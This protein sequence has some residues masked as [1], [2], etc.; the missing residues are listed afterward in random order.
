LLPQWPPFL[1]LQIVTFICKIFLLIQINQL[2]EA[3]AAFN[4]C[5]QDIFS[6]LKNGGPLSLVD[7][8]YGLFMHV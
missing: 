4:G 8:Q 2:H 7:F 3:Y 5:G 1:F 6:V